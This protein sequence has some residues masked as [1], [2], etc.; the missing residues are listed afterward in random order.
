MPCPTAVKWLSIIF[1]SIAIVSG[2]G[3][4][5]SIGSLSESKHWVPILVS[6]PGV[7]KTSDL[8]GGMALV[9]P[10]Q[11]W[12]TRSRTDYMDLNLQPN[13]LLHTSD[14]GGSWE[15]LS[16][17]GGLVDF[18]N[19]KIGW[20]V[21]YKVISKT[22]DGGKTWTYRQ[23]DEACDFL[24]ISVVSEKEAWAISKGRKWPEPAIPD[25]LLHT[26]DGGASWTE[27][28]LPNMS[29][30]DVSFDGLFFLDRNHGWVICSPIIRDRIALATIWR[31]LIILRTEDGG[32]TFKVADLPKVRP[33]PVIP[34]RLYFSNPV[35]GWATVGDSSALHTTDGG[36]TWKLVEL[37]V[38]SHKNDIGIVD[39]SFPTPLEGWAVGEG[40]S[41]LHT[42]DGG[43]TWEWIETGA[44]GIK[45]VKLTR[46][47]FF[48]K[49][50]GWIAGEGGISPSDFPFQE[51]GHEI[52]FVLKY[53]P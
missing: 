22:C 30:S 40:G 34:Y 25:A 47:V 33:A 7:G 48:D 35:E 46:V 2:C 19:D 50:H 53:V 38:D 17:D 5:D 14:S 18:V 23:S 12:V 6:D 37:I 16:V 3:S 21:G 10:G 11:G 31:Q 8:Y 41:A 1:V 39:F 9:G 43:K 24:E 27:V 45:N 15:T 51:P 32:K 49:D 44:E 29:T 13:E 42:Q 28:A 26:T 36:R 20:V 4:K 52:S